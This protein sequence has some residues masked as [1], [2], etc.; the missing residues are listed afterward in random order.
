M[1]GAGCPVDIRF[2]PTGVE[3]ETEFMTLLMRD[4]ENKKL[5]KYEMT[6]SVVRG[7]YGEIPIHLPRQEILTEKEWRFYGPHRRFKEIFNPILSQH[8]ARSSK[9]LVM[10]KD[11]N[12]LVRI[13]PNILHASK[14]VFCSILK[15]SCISG[16]I[17]I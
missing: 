2:A 13:P 9:M 7:L 4:K 11:M 5:G 8:T 3:T 17:V 15:T 14:R 10:I 6:V 1:E 12:N 16:G